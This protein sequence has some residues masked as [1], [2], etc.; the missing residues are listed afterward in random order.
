MIT[1][2]HHLIPRNINIILHTVFSSFCPLHTWI[3]AK[4]KKKDNKR[5]SSPFPMGPMGHSVSRLSRYLTC[6][7]GGVAILRYRY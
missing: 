3:R 7:R 6:V 2:H 1:I 4:K 5:Y